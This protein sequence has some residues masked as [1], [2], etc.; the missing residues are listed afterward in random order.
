MVDPAKD[1]RS[2]QFYFPGEA[3]ISVQSSDGVV[4]KIH[5]HL[6]ELYCQ[7]LPPTDSL[8]TP[9]GIYILS[10]PSSI[11][12]KVLYYLYPQTWGNPLSTDRSFDEVVSITRA[13]EKYQVTLAREAW[14]QKI[15]DTAVQSPVAALAYAAQS[16]NQTLF[17]HIAPTVVQ[18]DTPLH[19][20]L[21]ALPQI[22]WSEWIY[23]REKWNTAT[24]SALNNIPAYEEWQSSKCADC[25][26]Y[27]CSRIPAI[28]TI[29]RPQLDVS[30]KLASSGNFADLKAIDDYLEQ[31]TTKTCKTYSYGNKPYQL[32]NWRNAL[33]RSI[34][35]I[36]FPLVTPGHQESSGVS[37]ISRTSSLFRFDDAD[38]IICSADGVEFQLHKRNLEVCCGAFPPSSHPT[39]G[40]VV[41]LTESGA[42]LEMLFQFVYSRQQPDWEA[43]EFSKLQDL[44]EAVEKYEIHTAMYLCK[45]LMKRFVQSHPEALFAYATKHGY[46]DLADQTALLLLKSGGRAESLVPLLTPNAVLAWTRYLDHVWSVCNKAISTSPTIFPQPEPPTP[47]P[48]VSN[49]PSTGSTKRRHLKHPTRSY[50]T[51]QPQSPTETRCDYCGGPHCTGES[52]SWDSS[53]EHST[54]LSPLLKELVASPC[55]GLFKFDTLSEQLSKQM[56]SYT[57]G[58]R[59]AFRKWREGVIG[60]IRNIPAFRTFL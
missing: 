13:V 29:Q 35:A 21:L 41:H 55:G 24:R 49:D 1:Q 59:E 33:D 38:I 39:M 11:L 50:Q 12:E 16:R 53:N 43:L 26:K 17:N 7:G 4:Y 58:S 44:A 27:H 9:D 54:F 2:T 57:S 6:T 31:L 45:M 14:L 30:R 19:Q 10:E 8:M 18:S 42:T 47:P 56:A 40:E 32:Q 3:Y 48:Q 46:K 15:R 52:L 37:A 34:E 22:T 28:G 20:V 36:P 23:Y 51:P 5:K 60:D 25:D